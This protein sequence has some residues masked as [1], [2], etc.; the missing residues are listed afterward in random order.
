[1]FLCLVSEKLFL[2]GIADADLCARVVCPIHEL[3]PKCSDIL[4]GIWLED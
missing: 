1:M 4:V 2:G 3:P